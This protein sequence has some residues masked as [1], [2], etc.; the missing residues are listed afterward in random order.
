MNSVDKIEVALGQQIEELQSLLNLKDAE[1]VELDQGRVG[2]ISRIDAIQHQQLAKSR[3]NKAI[4]RLEQ[5]ERVKQ[6]LQDAPDFLVFATSV[7]SPSHWDGSCSSPRPFTASRVCLA[8][9]YFDRTAQV[10]LG[11][12]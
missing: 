9:N 6:R 4:A 10:L 1:I 2:R 8:R 12:K 7:V 11:P 5:L 3:E